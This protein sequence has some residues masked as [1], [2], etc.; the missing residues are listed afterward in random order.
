[1]LPT[2]DLA[3][4][5]E[6]YSKLGFTVERREDAWGWAMLSHG[7]HRLMLDRSIAQGAGAADRS[8]IYLYSDD[9]SG[10]QGRI[11]K[12][13]I[14]A[15]ELSETFYGMRE[16]RLLDPDGNQIWIGQTTSHA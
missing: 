16:F 7:T 1:M 3:R 2:K 12:A 6:F 9:V 13:G 8:V 15:P 11:T 4:S 10:F 14:A 5:I